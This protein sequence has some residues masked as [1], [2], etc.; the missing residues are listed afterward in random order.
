MNEWEYAHLTDFFNKILEERSY[1]ISKWGND[2]DSR[3]TPNDWMAYI[4]KY[5]GKAVTMPWNANTFKSMLVK[6]AALCAA[7]YQ[8]CECTSGNMPK[9]HYD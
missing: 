4:C 8:W 7:A 2:F 9:R 1:Q 3:N 5:S 6:V